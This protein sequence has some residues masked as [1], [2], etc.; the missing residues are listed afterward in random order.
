LGQRKANKELLISSTPASKVKILDEVILN[1]LTE[2]L[3][4]IENLE[5]IIGTALFRK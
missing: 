5:N 1:L 2:F 3:L 4:T